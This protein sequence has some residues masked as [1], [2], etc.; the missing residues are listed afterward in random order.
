MKHLLFAT[1]LCL[2]ATGALNAQSNDT[3]II[4]RANQPGLPPERPP[5]AAVT[6]S[7]IATQTDSND[8]GVQ[9]LAETRKL[10]FKI[11]VSA[12]LQVYY[13]DNVQLAFDNSPAS[14]SDAI[15]VGSTLSV[16]A[17]GN[18]L[19]VGKGLLTPTIGLVYQN[20]RHGIGSDDTTRDDLD[21]D[22][23]S[24]PV[25]VSYRFGQGWEASAGVNSS[26][27]YRIHGL[28]DYKRIVASVTPSVSLR[29]VIPINQTQVLVV[30]GGLSH[31]FTKATLDSVPA[32][33]T[34]FR[35]D[36]NDK[37]NYSLDASYY[38]LK[39]TWTITPYARLDYAD[40]SH[41]QEAG[42]GTATNVNRDDLTASF[43]L[44][45]SY[46]I[47]AW[48]SARIFSNY[49]IRDSKSGA[50][51]YSYRSAVVGLGASVHLR[52]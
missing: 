34:A 15:V 31:A 28:G 12:D 23:Y 27:V 32:G 45:A 36:R 30:T 2:I 47:N 16:S 39:G 44:T 42:F 4:D 49:E 43:G 37:T 48:S 3:T 5:E 24:V 14:N 25:F 29:K 13:T 50:F 10:P 20:F 18:P 7:E 9:R 35:N 33:F 38:I 17:T 11:N 41:Y 51:D 40:Y 21:F 26:A 8:A 6:T 52:F 1:S 19:T 46:R 22:A